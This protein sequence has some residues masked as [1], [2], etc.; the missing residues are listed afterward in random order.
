M[1]IYIDILLIE[2]FIINLF[3]LLIT[4]KAL[5]YKYYKTVYIASI[6]GSL[7]TLVLFM[8][9]KI[10]ASLPFKIIVV[11]LMVMI[12][13]KN[14]KLLKN[15][16][17]TIAFII[18]SFTLCG[19]SFAFSMIDNYYSIFSDFTINDYSIKYLLIS[20][21]GLYVVIVRVIDYLRDRALIN[22]FI[23]DIEISNEKNTLFIKGL[24]DTGNALREPVTNLPCIIIESTFLENFNIKSNEEFSIP[25]RTIGED[26]NLK[27]FKTNTVRIRGEDEEWKVVE[28]IL[29]KCKNKLSKEN[30]F[31]ALLSRGVI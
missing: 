27:G 20:I 8:D 11:L 9:N 15:I 25:Y 4:L 31:N 1:V 28:V 12:S 10:L 21:M 7:Y 2:N 22:N 24:L 16:K 17:S 30:E 29:C 6:V 18:M 14:Y 26:G 13:T 5:R 19:F 23:Y 3:L